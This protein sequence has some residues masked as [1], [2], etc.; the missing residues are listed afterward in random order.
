MKE[1][2]PTTSPILIIIYNINRFINKHNTLIS[3][4]DCVTPVDFKYLTSSRHPL[5]KINKEFSSN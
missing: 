5:P 2:H 1:C 4:N 3:F